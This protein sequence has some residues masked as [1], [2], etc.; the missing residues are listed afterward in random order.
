MNNHANR[1]ILM[2]AAFLTALVA[3]IVGCGEVTSLA[4]DGGG[5]ATGRITVSTGGE[6]GTVGVV[7]GTG[8]EV[9][10]TGGVAGAPGTGGAT[11]GM[12]GSGAGGT[13]VA[14]DGGA[15]DASACPSHLMTSGFGPGVEPTTANGTSTGII[16]LSGSAS[17]GGSDGG[18]WVDVLK[19]NLSGQPDPSNPPAS[20]TGSIAFEV[21]QDCNGNAVDA[22]QSLQG[23]SVS[24]WLYIQGLS[25]DTTYLPVQ[26]RVGVVTAAGVSFPWGMQA[27]GL[28]TTACSGQGVSVEWTPFPAGAKGHALVLQF[29][30]ATQQP[31]TALVDVSDIQLTFKP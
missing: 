15:G 16:Q 8:G 11:G 6:G 13:S 30:N 17:G 12:A 18:A 9:V 28:T 10:A 26:W 21:A 14:I 19:A 29:I 27:G 31:V 5:G 3:S 20:S 22:D 23:Y 25:C 7:V 1:K 4:V 2:R 24:F